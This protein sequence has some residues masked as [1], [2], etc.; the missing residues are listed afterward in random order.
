MFTLEILTAKRI[1]AF[2]AARKQE[3]SRGI[4]ALSMSQNGHKR[5]LGVMTNFYLGDYVPWLDRFCWKK[6]M[7]AVAKRWD[8]VFQAI[9]DDHKLKLG[10]D[11][12]QCG[13]VTTVQNKLQPDIM[14]VILTR[15]RDVDD[16]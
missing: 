9:L 10:T 12:G 16:V 6:Q 7:Y 11:P 3:I 4:E 13:T 5:C 14:D 2:Q 15:P 8:Q 1:A